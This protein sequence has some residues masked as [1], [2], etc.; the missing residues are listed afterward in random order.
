[1]SMLQNTD[2]LTGTRRLFYAVTPNETSFAT[3]DEVPDYIIEAFP[4]F[5]GAMLL[6]LIVSVIEGKQDE[7]YSLADTI[8]SITA[9]AFMIAVSAMVRGFEVVAYAAI[10]K[11]YSFVTLPWDSPWTWILAFLGLDFMYYWFHRLAHEVNMLWAFHQVHHS[12]EEYN[13]STALRQSVFQRYTS[14]VFYTVL[15][16]AL[17]A[18]AIYVHVQFNTLY[19]F[20][21]HTR[22]IKSLG[23]LEYILNTPSHHRVHHGRN[24]YCIDKNYAGTLIIWDRLFGTFEAEQEEEVVYGLVH[25][26]QTFDPIQTQLCHMQWMWQQFWLQQGIFNKLCVIFKGPGWEPGK[27]RLGNIED[28]PD[29]KYPMPKYR[30]QIAGWC[31]V[32]V[33]IHFA[34]NIMVMDMYGSKYDMHTALGAMIGISFLIYS[35]TCVGALC[36]VKSYAPVLE[37]IRCVMVLSMDA[38][39]TRSMPDYAA[40]YYYHLILLRVAFGL[41]TL[42]WIPQVL[43]NGKKKVE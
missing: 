21:I 14:W 39:I 3:V 36:D 26:I 8:G 10:N 31:Q 30:T 1:M 6:E 12:S 4:Y 22:I 34:L 24:R 29:I 23:P 9:G 32:Y 41:S 15:A 19:Q 18:S 33:T 40:V 25:P 27:P 5:M 13:L 11:H 17:P 2:P 7:R 37:L 28:I 35:F 20:W 43:I 38:Y 16:L 42:I